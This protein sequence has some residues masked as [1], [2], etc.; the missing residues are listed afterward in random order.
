MKHS[1]APRQ[2]EKEPTSEPSSDEFKPICCVASRSPSDKGP[3]DKPE[4]SWRIKRTFRKG[5]VHLPGGEFLMGTDDKKGFSQAGEG[6][7]RKVQLDPFWIDRCAVSNAQFEEFVAETDSVT[8][9]ERFGWSFVF[10]QF[11]SPRAEK[12]VIPN[13]VIY[14]RA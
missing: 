6:P 8:D 11:L 4:R 10:Y 14:F 7:V 13:P 1:D 2:R 3:E 5:I 12:R 9:A